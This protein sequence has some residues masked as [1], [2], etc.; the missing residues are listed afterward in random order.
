MAAPEMQIF[1]CDRWVLL[2]VVNRE[3]LCT[4]TLMALQFINSRPGVMPP[5]FKHL[6]V[7]LHFLMQLGLVVLLLAF[8]MC[9]L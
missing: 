2:Q 5:I 3:V 8:G 7:F 6:D 9:K 1:L 4:A